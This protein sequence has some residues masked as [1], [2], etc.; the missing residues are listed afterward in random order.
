MVAGITDASPPE[1]LIL[2]GDK[3][4]TWEAESQPIFS[5]GH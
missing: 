4:I 2:H 1:F 3:K 5:H